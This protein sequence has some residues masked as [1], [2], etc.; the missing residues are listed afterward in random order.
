MLRLMNHHRTW[1]P[2]NHRMWGSS[3]SQTLTH[4]AEIHGN[5]ATFSD[6]IP[7][8]RAG[9]DSWSW[10]WWRFSHFSIY[11][12]FKAWS[13]LM[14]EKYPKR[15]WISYDIIW[16]I[17]ISQVCLLNHHLYPL[18]WPLGEKILYSRG[19]HINIALYS[20]PLDPHYMHFLPHHIP[21]PSWIFHMAGASIKKVSSHPTALW[22]VFNTL[23]HST[24][25]LIGFFFMYCDNHQYLQGTIPLRQIIHRP[26]FING[27][28]ICLMV[29]YPCKWRLNMLNPQSF[30]FARSGLLPPKNIFPWSHSHGENEKNHR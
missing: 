21:V 24:D 7:E 19:T 29:F 4:A 26:S 18:S 20:M 5:F 14:S 6:L 22:A 13:F 8:W 15:W 23:S 30:G 2:F 1:P 25:W 3:F 17:R 10:C 12:L 27:I 28:P 9:G 11:D 16:M